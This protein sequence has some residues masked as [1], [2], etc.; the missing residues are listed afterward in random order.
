LDN[1]HKKGFSNEDITDVILTHLHF[2]HAGGAIRLNEENRLL[3]AFPK[4]TYWVTDIQ[5]NA[6]VNPTI[7]EAPSFLIENFLPL[8]EWKKIKFIPCTK[9]DYIFIP[10]LTL[11]FIHGHSPGMMLPIIKMSDQSFV[12]CAD[13]IPTIHHLSLS[14]II[15]YDIQPLETIKER[16][17]LIEEA[18]KNDYVLILEH[19]A[20]N[21]CVK[22]IRNEN[23]K[24]KAIPFCQ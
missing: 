23:G 11:R 20:E 12:F 24:I 1:L 21:T 22:L 6:A 2:D 4:A 9:E 7:K 3:P 15:A 10:G 5:W 18:F 13:L 17:S 14:Y 19:D 8:K 16:S